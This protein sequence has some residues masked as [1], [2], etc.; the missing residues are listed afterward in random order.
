MHGEKA[1]EN[2][3]KACDEGTFANIPRMFEAT[4]VVRLIW[5]IPFYIQAMVKYNRVT[6]LSH[7]VCLGYLKM[8]W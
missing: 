2:V 7:P 5:F 3:V 1:Q 4:L 8:K 6:C